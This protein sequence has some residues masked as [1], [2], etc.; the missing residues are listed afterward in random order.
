MHGNTPYAGRPDERETTS[1]RRRSV[2]RDLASVT[3]STRSLLTDDF[4]V[5]GELTEGTNGLSAT[6]AVRPPVGQVVTVQL[7]P[8]ELTGDLASELA[9]GAALQVLRSP[10]GV[11]DHAS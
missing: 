7:D 5:G 11:P 10:E 1:A 2:R 9:A 4:V 8:D 3:A 6:V